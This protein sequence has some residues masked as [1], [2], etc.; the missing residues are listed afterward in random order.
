M[1]LEIP[2]SLLADVPS[3]PVPR[4]GTVADVAAY[5]AEFEAIVAQANDQFYA[6]RR[7][8]ACH[9]RLIAG[10]VAGCGDT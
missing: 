5:I 1:A 7:L 3:R 6:A 4:G 10:E 8:Q 9:R 2:E